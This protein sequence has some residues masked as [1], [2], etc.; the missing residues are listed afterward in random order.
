MTHQIALLQFQLALAEAQ[1]SQTR[2]HGYATRIQSGIY[3]TRVVHH[4]G[5]NGPL[6]TEEELLANEHATLQRH[7]HLAEDHLE[8]AK[9]II[10]TLKGE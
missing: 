2:A 4:G 8:H 10:F 9:S 1:Q 6:F 5:A 3:K 7:L